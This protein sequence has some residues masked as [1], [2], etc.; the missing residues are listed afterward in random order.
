MRNGKVFLIIGGRGTGK[1]TYLERLLKSKKNVVV[2]Q[3]FIDEHYKFADK[4][5]YSDFS[6]NKSLINKV[7]VIEDATQLIGANPK[8]DIRKIVVS[9]KQMGS[10]VFFVFHS[11][12]VVPPYLWQLFDLALIFPSAMPKKTAGL[13]EYFDEIYK[14]VQKKPKPYRPCG[15]LVAH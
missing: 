2:F 12:N 6:I 9:S 14:I 4:R 7:L 10:D 1:T 15:V 5:L 3:L 13:A 8:N 11:A